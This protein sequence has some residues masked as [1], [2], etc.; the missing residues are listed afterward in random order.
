MT[1]YTRKYPDFGGM[2]S[3]LI[4]TYEDTGLLSGTLLD[5]TKAG[6]LTGIHPGTPITPMELDANWTIM[7]EHTEPVTA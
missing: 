5:Y 6:K 7:L 1:I 2:T 3:V 4:L